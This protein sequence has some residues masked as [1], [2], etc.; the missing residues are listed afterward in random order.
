MDGAPWVRAV[1]NPYKFGQKLERLPTNSFA[2]NGLQVGTQLAVNLRYLAIVHDICRGIFVMKKH[3]GFG[4]ICAAAIALFVQAAPAFATPT[5]TINVNQV[6][7]GATPAGPPPWLV[8][9]FTQTGSNTGTL[10]L[11]SNLTSPNFLQGLNSSHGTVGWAFFLNQSL[12]AI[13]CASGTCGNGNSG[14]NASGFNTGPVGDI[15]NLGFGWGPGSSHRFLA[16]SSAEYDLTFGSALTGDPFGVNGSGWS[17]VAHV[18]GIRV[19]GS[20]WI[21][22]GTPSVAVPE[23]AELGIFGLGVLLIGLFA[24]LRRRYC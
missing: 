24:G 21:V 2:N 12:S 20:G 6:Y 19:G 15:F 18:Q 10:T 8:A 16:G 22:S 11:T 1:G 3:V 23:P 14:F 5:V 4:L 7:T 17:S 9:T 13:T